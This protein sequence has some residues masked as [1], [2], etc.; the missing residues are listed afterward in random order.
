VTKRQGVEAKET[1]LSLSC[2]WDQK[3]SSS[4]K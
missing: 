1:F 3:Q 4:R 2:P